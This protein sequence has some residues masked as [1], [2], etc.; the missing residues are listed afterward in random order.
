MNVS[1]RICMRPVTYEGVLSHMNEWSYVRHALGI[2]AT[3]VIPHMYETSHIWRCHITHEWMAL[4]CQEWFRCEACLMHICHH[5]SFIHTWHDSFIC[6]R[7]H[8][9][10]V[11]HTWHV[12][13][14]HASHMIIHSYVIW[15]LHMWQVSYICDVTHSYDTFTC[16]RSHTHSYDTLTWHIH[17]Y[18]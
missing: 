18:A 17:T 11:S 5:E 2:R 1:H 4:V 16:D 15:H 6:D 8:T 13:L 10:V 12:C 7:S 9:Y 3:C 14:R